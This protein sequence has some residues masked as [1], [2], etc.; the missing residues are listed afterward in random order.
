M[1]VPENTPIR[2]QP[3]KL[4]LRPTLDQLLASERE[5]NRAG[6]EFLK[7]DVATAL[8][9]ADTALSTNDPVK[10][11]RNRKSARKAYDTVVRIAKKIALTDQDAKHLEQGLKRLRANLMQLGESF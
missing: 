7:A 5:M 1:G 4:L 2:R 11:S 8:T 10:K 9:F 3:R 6:S